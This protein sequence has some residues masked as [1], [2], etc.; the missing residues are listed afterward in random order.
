MLEC[1]MHQGSLNARCMPL[2]TAT[3]W[4]LLF[5]AY[6]LYILSNGPLGRTLPG[7]HSCVTY[8]PPMLQAITLGG[9]PLSRFCL[10]VLARP[11]GG[12]DSQCT[13][14]LRSYL[15]KVR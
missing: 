15:Y 6:H 12:T 14:Y 3:R 1:G 2:I 9:R 11:G 13:A 7:I 4:A 5:G 10:L 8:P